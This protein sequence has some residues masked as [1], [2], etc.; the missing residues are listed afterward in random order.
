[1]RLLRCTAI[2]LAWLPVWAA[3]AQDGLVTFGNVQGCDVHMKRN[4]TDEGTQ[5]ALLDAGKLMF[6]EVACDVVSVGKQNGRV[7][8]LTGRCVG[9]EEVYEFTWNF[10]SN[11]QGGFV[12]ATPDG[13]YST[14]LKA[15]R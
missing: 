3:A 4:T 5:M 8:S 10:R 14:V 9:Y 13:S 1:M 12:L 11:G 7:A 6:Y 15:C 2:L